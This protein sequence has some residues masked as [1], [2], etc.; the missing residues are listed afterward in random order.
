MFGTPKALPMV[1]IAMAIFSAGCLLNLDTGPGFGILQSVVAMG[2]ALP[3]SSRAAGGTAAATVSGQIVG[4]LPCDEV[5]G[6]VE[7]DGDELRVII[8]L[9]ADRQVCS[10]LAPTTFSYIANLLNVEAGDRTIIVEHRYVGVDGVDGVRLD[11]IIV[12]G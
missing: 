12:V 4:K 3:E 6:E 8:T 1:P 11:T 9:R 2:E 5:N 7:E 10:G